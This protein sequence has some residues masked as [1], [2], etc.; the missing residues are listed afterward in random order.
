MTYCLPVRGWLWHR[1][2]EKKLKSCTLKLKLEAAQF[3]E[4]WRFKYMPVCELGGS[5]RSRE[6]V[7]EEVRYLIK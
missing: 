3:A 4:S 2:V 6:L 7:L 1:K 5:N